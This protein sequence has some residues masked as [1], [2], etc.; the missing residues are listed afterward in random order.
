MRRM[1][2]SVG[3]V[4]VLR[5]CRRTRWYHRACV[6]EVW[7]SFTS[8]AWR[9][10]SRQKSSRVSRRLKL[11][12]SLPNKNIFR[13]WHAVS[14]LAGSEPCVVKRCEIC[15]A[16]LTLDLD[17]FDLEDYCRRHRWQQVQKK[18]KNTKKDITK[19]CCFYSWQHFCLLPRVFRWASPN[20]YLM[21]KC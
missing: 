5:V 10:G 11:K 17:T 19:T 3:S 7:A 15:M 8:S 16:G 20:L 4:T 1:R 13:V 14:S 18:K 6:Q 9:D 21:L 12:S 2:T